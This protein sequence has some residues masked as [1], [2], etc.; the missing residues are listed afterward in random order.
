MISA[1]Q[2]VFS[3]VHVED[4]AAATVVALDAD[5]GV[6]NAVDDDPSA[7]SVGLLAFARFLGA[8]EPPHISEEGALQTTGADSVYYATCLRGASSAHAKRKLG[9]APGNLEWLARPKAAAK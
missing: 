1:G 3:F 7:M 9:F 8:P 6:Y 2:G 5:P 4:A